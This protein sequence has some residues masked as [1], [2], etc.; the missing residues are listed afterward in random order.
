MRCARE[1]IHSQRERKRKKRY[2]SDKILA[3]S[4][5]QSNKFNFNICRMSTIKQKKSFFYLAEIQT[6]GTNSKK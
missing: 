3:S 5:R 2:K 1:R 4:F 6:W